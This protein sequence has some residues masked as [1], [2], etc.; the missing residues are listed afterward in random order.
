MMPSV[1]SLGG[2]LR[3]GKIARSDTSNSNHVLSRVTPSA[4][5]VPVD[6]TN[7]ASRRSFRDIAAVNFDIHSYTE[8]IGCSRREAVSSDHRGDGS[9]SNRSS[10]AA[11]Q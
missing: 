11:C 10:A 9:S 6:R 7:D 2:M 4:L 1:F 5:R 3:S 8:W